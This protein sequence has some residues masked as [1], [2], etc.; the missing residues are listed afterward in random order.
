M[1]PFFVLVGFGDHL[2]D[3]HVS[4]APCS[5][6][7]GL[8]IYPAS[9]SCDL[10]GAV[11]VCLMPLPFVASCCS[12]SVSF[13]KQGLG[14]R[15]SWMGKMAGLHSH[16]PGRP[17]PEAGDGCGK[18]TWAADLNGCPSQGCGRAGRK[19][20]AP[21]A[22]PY[23]VPDLEALFGDNMREQFRLRLTSRSRHCPAPD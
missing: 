15:T 18:G 8:V 7:A 4:F 12:R 5:Y 3:C 11:E 1:S 23:K 14:F 13:Y 20:K 21:L 16:C 19:L 10:V 9:C 22:T 17:E 2:D 6:Y